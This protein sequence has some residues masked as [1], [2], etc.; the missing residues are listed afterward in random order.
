M[1][2]YWKWVFGLVGI[3]GATTAGI[4]AVDALTKDETVQILEP[5]AIVSDAST[6]PAF[7]DMDRARVAGGGMLPP[8]GG[9]EDGIGGPGGDGDGTGDCD[10]T[11]D[12]DEAGTG[13][14]RKAEVYRAFGIDL[15]RDLEDLS[16]FESGSY[17]ASQGWEEMCERLRDRSRSYTGEEYSR[18]IDNFG[19]FWEKGTWM[20]YKLLEKAPN[21][22]LRKQAWE[23]LLPVV[24]RNNIDDDSIGSALALGELLD[25]AAGGQILGVSSGESGMTRDELSEYWRS[26]RDR[27]ESMYREWVREEVRRMAYFVSSGIYSSG[28][29]AGDGDAEFGMWEKPARK[30]MY[31]LFVLGLIPEGAG[32]LD[33]AYEAIGFAHDDIQERQ[34]R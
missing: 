32:G 9:P 2:N 23:R 11:G 15:D 17:P 22:E 1:S 10:V 18:E 3:S 24:F 13:P 8:A 16:E 29:T 27:S 31:R 14:D 28:M 12:R 21:D 5:P 30:S 19:T 7:S 4:L 25:R 33:L 26:L 34:D 6:D 20:F